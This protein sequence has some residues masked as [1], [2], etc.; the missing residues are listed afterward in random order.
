MNNFLVIRKNI[1]NWKEVHTL[2]R[3]LHFIILIDEA[4]DTF[5]YFKNRYNGVTE[6]QFPL[7]DISVHLQ[8]ISAN[9]YAALEKIFMKQVSNGKM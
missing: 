9:N 6:L 7:S 1:V 4:N 3:F 5:N 8:A 2:T